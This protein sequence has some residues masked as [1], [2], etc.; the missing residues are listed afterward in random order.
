MQFTNMKTSTLF[1]K[2]VIPQ[3]IGLVFNS[4]YFIVDGMFIGQRLGTDALAAAGVAVPV[5][6]IMIAF[7]MLLSVGTGVLVSAAAGRGDEAG[8]RRV[9]NISIVFT[10]ACSV[11]VAVCGTVFAA[12][13]ARALGADD[14]ILADTVTYMHYFLAFSPFLVFSFALS[15]YARNDGK[16]ALAMWSLIV[17]SVL[18]IV[19]DYV[20]MYPLNM[21]IA[22][23]ALATGL[24]PVSSVLLLLPHFLRKRGALYFTK[25][26]L[27]WRVIGRIGVGG[28]PAFV[29]EFSIGFVTL[30]YNLAIVRNGLGAD[31]LAVYI[32][33]GYAA[34]ICLTA[35]LGAAQGVQPAVSY[36][37]GAGEPARIR[38]LF[39]VTAVFNV[40]LGVAFYVLLLFGGRAFYGIFIGEPALLA[41]TVDGSMLYFTNLPFAAL[42]ILMISF[43]Q[44]MG[45]VGGAMAVSLARS[46]VPVA[47]LLAVLPLFMGQSGLWLAMTVAEI[48]TLVAGIF[49]WRRAW[50]VAPDGRKDDGAAVL[51]R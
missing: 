29:A 35:F 10:L 43:L 31:G 30:L 18:N 26:K 38:A 46:T 12:P 17:G 48:L 4:I 45:R 20:F 6:E 50:K 33:I 37:M 47:V 11:A 22:G 32:V 34:L 8:A 13:L 3:M 19:L 5:V 51:E 41:F 16:P 21:G 28:L 42:N 36:F 14:A 23:A 39:C 25:T 44:S 9:F 15:T 49:V 2:Y 1:L 7:S 27:S 40:V 24:G